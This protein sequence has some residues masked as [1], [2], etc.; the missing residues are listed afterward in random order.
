MSNG[1]L[2]K[3][4][5]R[6]DKALI[7]NLAYGLIW[8]LWFDHEWL[9]KDERCMESIVYSSCAFFCIMVI[10]RIFD[11]QSGEEIYKRNDSR[12][13]LGKILVDKESDCGML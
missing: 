7:E 3:L 6:I 12:D 11:V 5:L 1:M 2:Q 10:L 4:F 8:L 13:K 9:Y